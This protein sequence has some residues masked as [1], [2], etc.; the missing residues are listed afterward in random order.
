MRFNVTTEKGKENLFL[1]H[2]MMKGS[3]NRWTA[4]QRWATNM[5]NYN[6]ITVATDQ[7]HLFY[8]ENCYFFN[9]KLILKHS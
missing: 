1:S 8:I 4:A 5:N 3:F 9:N 6:L 2:M 7:D